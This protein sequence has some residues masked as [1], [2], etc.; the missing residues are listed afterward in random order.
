M[1]MNVTYNTKQNRC[2]NSARIMKR[3]FSTLMMSCLIPFILML[4]ISF[5]FF[6]FQAEDGI[7]DR[8]VTG[9]QTCALPIFVPEPERLGQ[10]DQDSGG[11][12]P[13]RSEE[14][15]VGKECVDLGGRRIIKKKKKTQ[16]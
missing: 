10:G 4:L 3:F 5:F 16:T 13:D 1:K 8:D 14:R 9:V 11:E 6:F 15:R 2:S 12:V 7:R